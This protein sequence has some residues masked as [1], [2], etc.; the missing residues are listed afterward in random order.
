MQPSCMRV[1]LCCLAFMS[2]LLVVRGVDAAPNDKAA[3]K[4]I[5]KAMDEDYF[6]TDMDGALDKLNSA[7]LMRSYGGFL[8]GRGR[9]GSGSAG[10][11]VRR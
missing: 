2:A 4:L 7:L 10:G 6:N 5:T 8:R 1:L 11:V 3:E 9:E